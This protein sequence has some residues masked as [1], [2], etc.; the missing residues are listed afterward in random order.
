MYYVVLVPDLA[1]RPHYCFM[2]LFS[3][4]TFERTFNGPRGYLPRDLMTP[5]GR[6]FVSQHDMEFIKQKLER[7]CL[8]SVIA[9][10]TDYVRGDDNLAVGGIFRKTQNTPQERDMAPLW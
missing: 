5:C 8:S 1:R 6:P 3:G 2:S 10:A 4:L 7:N 9:P